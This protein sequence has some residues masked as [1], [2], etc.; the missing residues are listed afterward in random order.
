MINIKQALK[1]AIKCLI[2]GFF[3]EI[4]LSADAWYKDMLDDNVAYNQMSEE[5]AKAKGNRV[6]YDTDEV[7]K[8][9]RFACEELCD[10]IEVLN[11]ISPSEKYVEM[12]NFINGCTKKY[13][14]AARARQTKSEKADSALEEKEG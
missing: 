6:N 11:R 4:N 8:N 2:E 1:S 9:L 5:R 12:A 3:C 7:Y 14:T 13:M 10:A